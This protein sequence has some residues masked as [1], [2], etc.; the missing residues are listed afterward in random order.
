MVK[1]SELLH[2]YFTDAIVWDDVNVYFAPFLQG[3]EREAIAQFAQMLV[4]EFAYR[5]L[6]RGDNG[7][8]AEISL[9]WGVPEP[10]RKREAIGP[11]GAALGRPYLAFEH[12]AQQLAWAVVDVLGRGVHSGHSLPGPVPRIRIDE[13]FFKTPGNEEFLLHAARVSA[14]RRTIQYRFHR[15]SG[16]QTAV[17]RPRRVDLHNVVLNLPRAAYRAGSEEGLAGEL[18]GLLISPSRRTTI[19]GA[20]WSSWV[21]ANR[22]GRSICSCAITNSGRSW[23]LTPRVAG[24]PSKGLTSAC[25]I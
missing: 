9:C 6:T 13:T 17:A 2:G 24:S 4:Y 8:P 16:A 15:E 25:S 5:A 11:G 14:E 20:F 21:R 3:R 7:P 23:T 18:R 12:T 10:L 1:F 19:S 22:A